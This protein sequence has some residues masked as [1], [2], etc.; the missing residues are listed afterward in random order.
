M[1]RTI[2]IDGKPVMIKATASTLRRYMNKFGTDLL[3][4][5]ALISHAWEAGSV[6]TKVFTTSQNLV[7]IMAKQADPSVPDDVEEWLDSFDRFPLSDFIVDAM[8][9]WVDSMQTQVKEKK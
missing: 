1:E 6:D 2:Q 7:Y 9:L 5:F 3:K 8:T 4:D